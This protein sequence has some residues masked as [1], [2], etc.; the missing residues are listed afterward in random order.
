MTHSPS[1][2]RWRAKP[3][4]PQNGV[5]YTRESTLCRHSSQ[6]LS[7]IPHT[8]THTQHTLNTLKTVLRLTVHRLRR[9]TFIL[10]CWTNTADGAARRYCLHG[11]SW[12]A[13]WY[14]YKQFYKIRIDVIAVVRIIIWDPI[15]CPHPKTTRLTESKPIFMRNSSIHC[16][17]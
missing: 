3:T 5:N 17:Q 6:R 8:N 10:I 7:I 13:R 11:K 14:S 9:N 12:I 2:T 1:M 4:K 15:C 16:K